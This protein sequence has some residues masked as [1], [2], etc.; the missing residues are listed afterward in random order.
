[1]Q[2]KHY[3][4]IFLFFVFFQFTKSQTIQIQGSLIDSISKSSLPCGNVM[5]NSVK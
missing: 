2:K 5:I 4:L 1:M 3:V